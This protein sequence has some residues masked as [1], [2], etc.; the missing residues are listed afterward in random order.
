M[1]SRLTD[2]K[3][4]LPTMSNGLSLSPGGRLSYESRPDA[5]ALR[6][7]DLSSAASDRLEAAFRES[8]AAG[9]IELAKSQEDRQLAPDLLFWREFARRLFSAIC[10]LGE[11]APAHWNKVPPPSEDELTELVASAPPMRGLEYLD[12][13][14]LQ[15]LWRE[16][17]SRVGEEST[18]WKAGSAD[19]LQHVDP[20]FHQLGR[21]TFH[22]AEN[23]R[24][25][26]RPFAFLATFTHRLTDQAKVAHIPLAEVTPGTGRARRGLKPARARTP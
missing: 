17:A 6:T 9:L 11:A 19:Y 1:Y 18:A 15:S 21:V 12:A 2:D 5:D 4:M 24:D 14:V 3:C 16:L 8:T 23:K 20:L 22:L 10:S 25:P 26:D 13:T 7:T